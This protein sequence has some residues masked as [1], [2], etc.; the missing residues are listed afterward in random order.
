MNLTN[1][2]IFAP[3]IFLVGCVQFQPIG[4]YD[5]VPAASN[6]QQERVFF[7]ET[8]GQLWTNLSSCGEVSVVKNEDDNVLLLE[9]NKVNCDWVGFGNSW[10]NFVADDISDIIKTSAIS[11]KVKAVDT[12]QNS[13]P[14]VIGLEDY[15]GGSSYVF[16]HLN[17][18][19]NKLIISNQ[20][21]TTYYM[22]LWDYDFTEAGVDPY[23]IKQMIIQLEGSGKVYL[24]DIQLT[25]YSKEEYA[26]MLEDVEN[27]KVKGNPNQNIY[28]GNFADMA[29]GSGQTECQN[30]EEQEQT[31]NW[32]WSNCKQWNTWGINWNNWYAFNLRGIVEKTTLKMQ[33]SANSSPFE[34]SI[35]DFNG[36][37]SKVQLMGYTKVYVND[38]IVSISIPLT[39]FKILEKE[40]VLD[41][42]KQLQFKGLGAGSAKIHNIKFSEK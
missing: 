31:I 36:H 4:V 33:I 3:L 9:W 41:R 23:G 1:L 32:N 22:P 39:D 28:P 37:S 34:L 16:T 12:P 19:A 27:Y 11:F 8:K 25:T 18:Y 7:N 38:T 6:E 5:S 24:D 20:E 10:S 2:K 29:W 35:E 13:I 40:F 26:Q 21:W 17:L 15:S 42:M 30:L 14:F